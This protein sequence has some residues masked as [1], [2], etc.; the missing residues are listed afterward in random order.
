VIYRKSLREILYIDDPDKF[1]GASRCLLV[2]DEESDFFE[3]FNYVF[4]IY[5]VKDIIDNLYQQKARYNEQEL[6]S[7]IKFYYD[8]DCFIN[9]KV[10]GGN[11]K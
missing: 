3:G 8:N 11:D 6:F 4:G 1:F 5:I 10:K 9:L 2:L 7:A